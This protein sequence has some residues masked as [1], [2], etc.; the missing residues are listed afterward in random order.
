LFKNTRAMIETYLLH[1]AKFADINNPHC[2]AFRS[3]FLSELQSFTFL[4]KY[5]S[6]QSLMYETGKRTSYSPIMWH[7]YA[8]RTIGWLC[9]SSS[10]CKEVR[11]QLQKDRGR[12]LGTMCTC[13]EIERGIPVCKASKLRPVERWSTQDGKLGITIQGPPLRMWKT[14]TFIVF[15]L[16]RI[17]FCHVSVN[18]PLRCLFYDSMNIYFYFLC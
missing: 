17:A 2:A 11:D 16:V 9:P 10:R 4:W 13:E 7:R 3:N 15:L 14:D 18:L 5:S 6:S 8:K 12:T 1:C